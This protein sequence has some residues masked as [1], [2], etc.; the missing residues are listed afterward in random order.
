MLFPYII[1]QGTDITEA[2][3]VHHL[4]FAKAEN[5]LEDYYVR[6]AVLPRNFKLTFEETGFYRT[7]RRR[8]GERLKSIDTSQ[9]ETLSKVCNHHINSLSDFSNLHQ[10]LKQNHFFHSRPIKQNRFS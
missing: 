4:N 10:A 9:A 6:E 5:L 3:E 2:F 1:A 8:I 7:L